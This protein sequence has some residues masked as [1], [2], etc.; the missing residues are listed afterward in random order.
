M[1]NWI[2]RCANPRCRHVAPES[3]WTFKPKQKPTG[4]ERALSV[5]E[6]HCPKCDCK[7]FYKATQ[8]EIAK[9]GL[10]SSAANAGDVP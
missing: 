5:S 7:T 6:A 1:S 9:A 2:I 4:T 3:D 10:Q 8:K